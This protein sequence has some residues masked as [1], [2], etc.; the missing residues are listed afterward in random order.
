MEQRRSVR[1][2]KDK[3][4]P[5]ETLD[6]IIDASRVSPTG[7][8]SSSTGV[9]VIDKQ[10]SLEALSAM[11]HDLYQD[12]DK[13]LHKPIARFIIRR[14]IGYKLFHSLQDFVMPGM[15]WYLKWKKEGIGDEIL[16][17]CGALILFHCPTL[18]PMGE[19]NCTLSA[20]HAILMAEILGVGTCFS[21]IVPLGCNRSKNIRDFLGL[22]KDREFHSSITLGFPKY[23][24][25]RVVPKRLAEVRYI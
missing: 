20:F 22:P 13:N 10:E 8:G 11:L 3:S 1:R 18:E 14:R 25:H 19:G 4:V 17:E 23:K 16:R 7:T 2:Y 24:Y 5:R 12:L 15:R 9:L 21:H 6:R